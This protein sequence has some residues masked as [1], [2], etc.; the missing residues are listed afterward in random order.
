ME[1]ERSPTPGSS[2]SAC[3]TLAL[4]SLALQFAGAQFAQA[5]DHGQ[6]IATGGD[7]VPIGIQVFG[8]RRRSVT[9]A[10]NR[11]RLRFRDSVLTTLIQLVDHHQGVAR[12]HLSI[13]IGVPGVEWMGPSA[14]RIA[15]QQTTPFESFGSEFSAEA[16]GKSGNS[17]M[18]FHSNSFFCLRESVKQPCIP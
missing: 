15:R 12:S 1:F 4:H 5:I 8:F 16:T 3:P 9:N 11:R 10:Q 6:R 18:I 13:A 2:G 17:A 14:E 7:T